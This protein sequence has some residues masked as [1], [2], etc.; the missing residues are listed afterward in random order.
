ME[1][2]DRIMGYFNTPEPEPLPEPDAKLALAALMV[3]IAKADKAYAVEEISRID[4]LLQ[5]L[6]A[7]GPVEAAKM[8]A[9]CEKLDAA[10]PHEGRFA[11]LI[12]DSLGEA[13]R[14]KA[15]EAL[16]SV[17]RADGIERPEEEDV[18]I[19]TATI[20]G[21]GQSELGALRA[22]GGA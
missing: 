9:T 19:E 7:L 2:V 17:M 3:R 20:L 5:E 14:L 4:K 16:H 21:F 12:R 11:K 22:G 18:L 10:A 6:Y 13:D 1:L 15:V 8:R